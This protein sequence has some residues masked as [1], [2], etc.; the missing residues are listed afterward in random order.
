MPHYKADMALY[1]A[2]KLRRSI[3]WDD[4]V[5]PYGRIVVTPKY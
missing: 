4:K 1:S 3:G 2:Q 5:A